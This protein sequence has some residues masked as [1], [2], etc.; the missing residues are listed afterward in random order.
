MTT[1]EQINDATPTR[2]LPGKKKP[3]LPDER[4]PVYTILLIPFILL[5]IKLCDLYDWLRS[6]K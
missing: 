1:S 5:L 4:P 6:N 2:F 3:D